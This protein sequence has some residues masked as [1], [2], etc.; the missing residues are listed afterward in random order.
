[1]IRFRIRVGVGVG[2]LTGLLFTACVLPASAQQSPATNVIVPPLV[3][4]GGLLSDVNGK[5]L[6]GIVGVTF[7]LYKDS[8]GGVPLWMETQ[9]VQSDK[10]G[11]YSVML[12]STTSQGLPADLFVSGEA[13]WLGVQIEA[14]SEQPRIMLLSVPYAMKAGDAETVGGLPASAS[15]FWPRRRHRHHRVAPQRLRQVRRRSLLPAL[16]RLPAR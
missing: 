13:R 16:R 15:S 4:F 9:N 10:T 2:I 11:H 14:Q 12:G 8:Q 6:A 3:K 7:S 1:M 5:P